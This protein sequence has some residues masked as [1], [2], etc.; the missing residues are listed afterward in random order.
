MGGTPT[1]I[2]KEAGEVQLDGKNNDNAGAL[3]KSTERCAFLLLLS[4]F[5]RGRGP[6]L[7]RDSR[8]IS[9]PSRLR[10]TLSLRHGVARLGTP[11]ACDAATYD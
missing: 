1:L 3:K 4:I 9:V 7:V 11:M 10:A 5:R 2:Q 6:A 8:R